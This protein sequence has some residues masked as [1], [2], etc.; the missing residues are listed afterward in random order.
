VSYEKRASSD[1]LDSLHA[2]QAATLMSQ[3]R[4]YTEHRNE[5]TGE[6][7]PLEVP[8][9][10]LA[11]VSKFLKDNSVDSPGRGKKLKDELKDSLPDLPDPADVVAEHLGHY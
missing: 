9:A 4:R 8:T 1:M 6:L 7:E 3:V 11:Q 2:L 10:L 5:E